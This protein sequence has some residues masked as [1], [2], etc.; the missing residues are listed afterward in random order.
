MVDH[1]GG[2]ATIVPDAVPPSRRTR[3]TVLAVVGALTVVTAA[4][5]V[6]RTGE[7]GTRA[8]AP[9]PSASPGAVS[10]GYVG[11]RWRLTTVTDSRGTTAMPASTGA[12]IDLAADGTLVAYDDINAVNARFAVTGA[13]F[14]VDAGLTTLAGYAGSDPA[15]LAA[16]AGISA[17]T[18]VPGEQTAHVTVVSADPEHLTVDAGGL[19]LAFSRSG[20]AGG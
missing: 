5:A 10:A 18:S 6:P 12:W 13:G 17:V 7:A 2:G 9:L 14:D 19:R 4:I 16:I 15:V 11:S 3:W 20:P 8:V 1:V